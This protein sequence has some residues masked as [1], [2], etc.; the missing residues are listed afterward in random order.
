MVEINFVDLIAI[1]HQQG[2]LYLII[3]LSIHICDLLWIDILINAMFQLVI[4]F[5]KLYD[6]A[7]T[8]KY[9]P[10]NYS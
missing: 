7:I 8:S 2:F 1:Q 5:C 6:R 9:L 4:S 3:S 10:Q